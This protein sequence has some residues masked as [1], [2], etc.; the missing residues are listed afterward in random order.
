MLPGVVAK[1]AETATGSVSLYQLVATPGFTIYYSSYDCRASTVFYEQTNGPVVSLHYILTSGINYTVEGLG[2]GRLE[3]GHYTVL[4][5]PNLQKEMRVEPGEK[6]TI[7]SVYLSV[8]FFAGMRYADSGYRHFLTEVQQNHPVF[9]KPGRGEIA[10]PLLLMILSLL[11]DNYEG[12]IRLRYLQAR[13]QGLLQLS[14]RYL[15]APPA[16]AAADRVGYA[17]GERILQA[18]EYARQYHHHQL[19][20]VKELAEKTGL[21][22][23]RFRKGFKQLFGASVTEFLHDLK[24][25]KAMHRVVSEN[26]PLGE[27]GES[28]GYSSAE[29][30]ITS[31]KKE[32]GVTPAALKIYYRSKRNR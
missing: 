24:M 31:F 19:Y 21:N 22:E 15:A 14:V 6:L 5:A 25:E 26:K 4:Y 20:T 16:I 2:G 8:P 23:H 3:E 27:I 29:S 17:D 12:D 13:L 30:F 18:I 7:L 32:F 11:R 9:F 10:P 1:I 28:L